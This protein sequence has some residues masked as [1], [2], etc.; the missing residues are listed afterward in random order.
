MPMK[1]IRIDL[2]GVVYRDNQWWI[3][4]CLEMDV[5]AEGETPPEAI[6]DLIALCDLKIKDALGEGDTRSIF[7][8]A[9]AKIWDLY[10]R[11]RNKRVPKPLP[12]QVARFD[13]REVALV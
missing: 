4:H 13:V 1:A 5:V 12:P 7:R 2:R 6:R 11:A 3:A 8:P 10:A 9:P